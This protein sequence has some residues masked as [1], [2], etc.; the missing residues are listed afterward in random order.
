MDDDACTSGQGQC[1]SRVDRNQ[2]AR[3]MVASQVTLG[4]EYLSP[5]ATQPSHWANTRQ[6]ARTCV[7]HLCHST[8]DSDTNSHAC[9]WQMLHQ[10]PLA[11][12][13]SS[14]ALCFLIADGGGGDGGIVVRRSAYSHTLHTTRRSGISLTFCYLLGILHHRIWFCHWTIFPCNKHNIHKHF[15]SAKDAILFGW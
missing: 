4:N 14:R 5:S 13:Q 3:W 2:L 1:V 10:S 12:R 6:Q 8:L 7:S 9:H 11:F 15:S